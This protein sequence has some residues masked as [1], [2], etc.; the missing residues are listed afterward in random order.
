MSAATPPR[1]PFQEDGLWL[2]CALH[3]HTTESDGELAPS[4]L[5]DHYARAGYDVLAITD[6]WLRTDAPANGRLVVLPST[7]LNVLLPGERDGHLL[8]LGIDGD[9][10]PLLAA[11]PDLA[12]GVSWVLER[13]GVAYLAHPYWT[14]APTALAFPPGLSGI[15]VYNA[16]CDLEVGRGLAAVHWDEA[17]EAGR[18]CYGIASDD[19]HLPGFDSDLAW[20]LVRSPE[21]SPEAVLAALASGAFYSSSGPVIHELTVTETAVEAL[22]TPARSITLCTGRE[23]GARANAGRLGLR[24]RAE[25][26]ATSDGGG[27]IAARLERPKGAQYGRLEVVDLLGRTAWTNPLWFASQSSAQTEL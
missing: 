13:G 12:A 8:G 23:R 9:P 3:A 5:A 17:L 18:L 24:H 25:V 2:R 19:S 20:V 16:G 10:T 22:T 27:I 11:R 15:E 6:H 4:Q 21:R 26:L 1:N 14:G 7:E